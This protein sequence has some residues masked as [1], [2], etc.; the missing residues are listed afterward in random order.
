MHESIVH[1]FYWEGYATWVN[2]SIFGWMFMI[3]KT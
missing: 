1:N 3:I 2:V